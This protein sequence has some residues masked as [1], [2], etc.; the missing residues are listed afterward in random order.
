MSARNICFT[1]NNPTEDDRKWCA[2]V[3]CDYIVYGDEVGEGGTPHIQGYIEFK[4]SKRFRTLKEMCPRAHYEK[5]AGTSKQ[6]SD[7]CKKDGHFVERGHL[8]RPGA[9]SDLAE[10][11]GDVA[12]GLKM[13]EVAEAHPIQFVK[14][15]RGLEKLQYV[16]APDRTE[17]PRV[18]WLWGLAGSGKSREACVGDFYIKD[19]SQ[20]WDGYE[21]QKR[22]VIDDFDA[23]RWNFRDL[24]RLLDRYPYQG[25][26][27]GGY[28]RI[29]SPEI[30][31]TCEFAPESCRW[32]GTAN[33][34]AQLLRR[35]AEIR[36][37][38][39]PAAL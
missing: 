22:I 26:T 18:V 12:S 7:Y 39:A 5:R 29:N 38:R 34:L 13:R 17:P 4:S 11:V 32:N 15:H 31:I 36:E 24:L 3:V 27:K 23:D 28:I 21:Y 8:S 6:A 37:V 20:W 33:S 10:V 16:L 14:Y 30:Y 25:Q 9:R 1:I 35:I 19:N 2:D